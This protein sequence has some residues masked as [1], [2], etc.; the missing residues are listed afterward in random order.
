MSYRV[1]GGLNWLCF[2]FAKGGSMGS[3]SHKV[4]VVIPD[5]GLLDL[6]GEVISGFGHKPLLFSNDQEAISKYSKDNSVAAVVIDWE[7]S[8]KHF[9]KILETLHAVSPYMGRFVFIDCEDGEIRKHVN[10]G[11]FCCY[12]RKPFN[13]ERLERGLLGCIDE[14]EETIKNCECS[15]S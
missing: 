12:M 10:N 9:P 15:C 13:L 5:N 8:R 2:I 6:L 11:D 1:V 4:L 3:K 14:Y 7:L